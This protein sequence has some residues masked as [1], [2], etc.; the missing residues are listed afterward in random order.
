MSLARPV[1]SMQ[2]GVWSVKV[3]VIGGGSYLWAFGFARQFV[4]SVNLNGMNLVLMDIDPDAL[5][6]TSSA[7]NIHNQA[8]GSPIRIE[9]TTNLDSALDGANF[10]IVSISTG[11]LDAMR[12]DLEIPEKYGITH[13]VG[14]T[15]GPGG[16][17][18]AVR[19]I[20]VFDDFGARMK[21]LCPD[22]WLINVSNPLTVLTRVPQRNHGIKTLGMCPGVEN[23]VRTLA[24]LVG[25]PSKARLDFAV[26]GIDHGSWFTSLHADNIDVLQKLKYMEY[27]RS[28][29]KLPA[30]VMSDDPL[31]ETAYFRASFAIWREI[32]YLPSI[33]D[34]HEVENWP[35]F[36]TKG[37]RT[38]PYG[39]KRTSVKEREDWRST[40]K[41][42]LEEYI[43]TGNDS[44][45][46]LGHGDDPVVEVIE[47]LM[48]NRSF[49]YASNYAN[50]GQIPGFPDGAVVETR[51]LIDGAGVHPIC[52]PMPDILKV[53]VLP[54]VLRQETI[55]DIALTGSFD[56]LVALV[57][58]D[59]LCSNVPVDQCR[60][61]VKEMLVANQEF[62]Q[63]PNLLVGF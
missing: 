21:R 53:L 35:W 47:S 23:A 14:D 50:I 36:L 17:L 13:T 60:D 56:E 31:A 41:A 58:T 12:H 52:S 16:W 44:F 25:A 48:G 9:T 34:R 32:G 42:E 5:D 30:Q 11:G 49:T 55:I 43:R 19:N 59:P 1:D 40:K 26:T 57:L 15:V 27:C 54:H 37:E 62:I 24:K 38:L 8:H 46:E 10:V 18:R 20:P 61:M 6:I 45:G 7:A 29:D 51:C 33:T 3:A 39:I 4:K 28:D 22:A 2:M 63:N